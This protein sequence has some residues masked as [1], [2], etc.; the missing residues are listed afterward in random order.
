VIR[1]TPP[2]GSESRRLAYLVGRTYGAQGGQVAAGHLSPAQ[3]TEAK[4]ILFVNLPADCIIRIYSSSGILVALLEHHS[5]VPGGST[6]E[7]C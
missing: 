7:T 3:S 1:R 5:S 2:F 6:Y 4:V